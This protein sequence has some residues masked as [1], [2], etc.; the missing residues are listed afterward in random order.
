MQSD[1]ELVN[2]VLDGEKEAFAVLVE[3]YE[4]AVRA[5]AVD[6]LRDRHLAADVSQDAFVRSFEQLAGLRKAETFGCGCETAE[7]G[8]AVGD[9]SV[10]WRQ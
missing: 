3:R 7:G 9:A 2:A 8:K 5:V 6:I 10:F 4:R 1:A